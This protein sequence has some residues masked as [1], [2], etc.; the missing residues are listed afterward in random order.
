MMSMKSPY[1]SYSRIKDWLNDLSLSPAVQ[2]PLG[3]IVIAIDNNQILKKKWGIRVENKSYHTVVT[4]VVAFELDEDGKLQCDPTLAPLT[5]RQINIA[6]EDMKKIQT[7]GADPE[8]RQVHYE[9]HLSPFVTRRL[10]KIVNEHEFINGHW[11]DKVDGKVESD[12]K[13]ETIKKCPGCQFENK[14]SSRKCQSCG[15]SFVSMKKESDQNAP[16]VQVKFK[17]SRVRINE[18]D[19][20]TENIKITNEICRERSEYNIY[21]C[22]NAGDSPKT[23][24]LKPSMVNPNSYESIRTCLVD[25]GIQA[26]IRKYGNGD[27][28]FVFLYCDGVPYNLIQRVVWCTFRCKMCNILLSS[29]VQCSQHEHDE[30]ELE[31]ADWLLVF[32]GAGHIEMNMLKSIVELLWPIC[33]REIVLLFNFRSEAALRSA[34]KVSDHHKGWT[35]ARIFRNALVDE[36]LVPYVRSELEQ[37]SVNIDTV[38]LSCKK[39][40]KFLDSAKNPNYTFMADVAFEFIDVIFMYRAGVRTGNGDMMKAARAIFAKMWVGRRHPQYRELEVQSLVQQVQMPKELQDFE[41]RSMSL[42]MS[43]VPCTAEGPDFRLEEINK[44]AQ[45]FLPLVPKA[46]DWEK[47]CSNFDTLTDIK[48]GLLCD[49]G[50]KDGTSGI[51]NPRDPGNQEAEELA[52]RAMFRKVK[53]LGSPQEEGEHVSISGEKLNP[54]LVRFIHIADEKF[55]DYV[56]ALTKHNKEVAGSKPAAPVWKN[57]D[58]VLVTQLEVEEHSRLDKKTN[59]ELEGMTEDEIAKI[60]EDGFRQEWKELWDRAVKKKHTKKGYIDFLEEVKAFNMDVDNENEVDHVD[61]DTNN[62]DRDNFL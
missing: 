48:K 46:S 12:K 7:I 50:S 30:V 25:V 49:K 31:F 54:A 10:V 52:V 24:V 6:E 34:Q 57:K 14:K 41:A 17:E 47:V 9:K 3:D 1:P 22:V 43:G 40:W 56:E 32:P 21:G 23:Y 4:M 51:W 26:G 37:Q 5:W 45:N 42:N 16:P 53:Y 59:E 62:E 35:I 39:F 36:L 61:E 29:K 38:Q 20:N 13:K 8:L 55:A 19:A 27:R 60:S 28:S 15:E 58:P 18:F 33:W 11:T 2:R 44:K